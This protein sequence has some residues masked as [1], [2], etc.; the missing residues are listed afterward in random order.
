MQIHLLPCF[1]ASLPVSGGCVGMAEVGRLAW[2]LACGHTSV[3]LPRPFRGYF[4]RWRLG[5][6][7]G[8]CQVLRIARTV[9]MP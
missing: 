3:A 8:V 2:L 9:R 6:P 1:L 7:T 5:I 4:F